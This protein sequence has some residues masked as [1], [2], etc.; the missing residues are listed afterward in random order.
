[1]SDEIDKPFRFICWALTTIRTKKSMQGRIKTLDA[2]SA[3]RDWDEVH[4]RPLRRSFGNLRQVHVLGMMTLSLFSAV[5]PAWVTYVITAQKIQGKKLLKDGNRIGRL[6]E[7][8]LLYYL[9]IRR[10]NDS[11]S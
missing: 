4:C 11:V 3:L 1:M 6:D 7:Q 2:N 10:A 5:I 8:Q 9:Q